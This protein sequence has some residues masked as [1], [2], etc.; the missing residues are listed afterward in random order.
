MMEQPQLQTPSSPLPFPRSYWVLEGRL[1]AGVYPGAADPEDAE[2]RL[3]ALL[4]IGIRC[5][6]NLTEEDEVNHI[7]LPLCGYAEILHDIAARREQTVATHR[8][9]IKDT[10]IPRVEEMRA[11]LDAIDTAMRQQQPVY[12]HC[13]GGKGRTATVVGC[14]LARHG[15]AVGDDALH[16]IQVFRQHDPTAQD[17]APENQLQCEFVRQWPEGR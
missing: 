15:M 16:A 12:L 13:W 4:N 10:N 1:L 17:P 8:F 14:W 11:I 9:P 7:G 6:I 5:V 2:A 3:A